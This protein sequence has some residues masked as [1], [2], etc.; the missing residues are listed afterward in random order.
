MAVDG[1]QPTL[2]QHGY[3]GLGAFGKPGAVH[4]ASVATPA[5]WSTSSIVTTSGRG[6]AAAA[7]GLATCR[8]A[9]LSTAG[10]VEPPTGPKTS[11]IEG[12][13][14]LAVGNARYGHHK[15]VTDCD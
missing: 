15:A 3:S 12:P 2:D 14:G 11:H 6:D 8:H 9:A 5:S 13:A 4:F 1:L 7:A 10:A